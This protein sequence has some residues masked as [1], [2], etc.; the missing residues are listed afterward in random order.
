MGAHLE[1]LTAR[2]VASLACLAIARA[3]LSWFG[4]SLPLP[5]CISSGG[6]PLNALFA[7]RFL[8]LERN[9]QGCARECE[10][11]ELEFSDSLFSTGSRINTEFSLVVHVNTDS[12]CLRKQRN[13]FSFMEKFRKKPILVKFWENV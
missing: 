10:K 4:M 3:S 7:E 1:Q 9:L 6:C 13:G 8:S 11:I 5:K 2:F 12:N